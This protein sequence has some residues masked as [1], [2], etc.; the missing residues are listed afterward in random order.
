MDINNTQ[1]RCFVRIAAVRFEIKWV[2]YWNFTF[3][4]HIK[5]LWQLLEK[6]AIAI[7]DC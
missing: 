3:G 5:D 2:S 4:K 7:F 1:Y 6:A